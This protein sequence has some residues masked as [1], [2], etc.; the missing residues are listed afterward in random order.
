MLLVV[1][2]FALWAISHGWIS[3]L[4]HVDVDLFAGGPCFPWVDRT[5]CNGKFFVSH[6][7]LSLWIRRHANIQIHFSLFRSVPWQTQC[8]QFLREPK[9]MT[10]LRALLAEKM[11]LSPGMFSSKVQVRRSI[12]LSQPLPPSVKLDMQSELTKPGCFHSM[13]CFEMSKV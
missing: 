12:C 1:I 13:A 3:P 8:V 7:P 11:M 4:S 2:L 5:Y 6:F 9:R 10:M